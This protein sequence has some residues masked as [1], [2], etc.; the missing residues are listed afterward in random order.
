[1]SKAQKKKMV[2]KIKAKNKVPIVRIER[3]PDDVLLMIFKNF[4]AKC[5]GMGECVNVDY[6]EN[7]YYSNE[8]VKL[9]F[10]WGHKDFRCFYINHHV[11]HCQLLTLRGVC[12]RFRKIVDDRITWSSCG[13]EN[14]MAKIK[15]ADFQQRVIHG[16]S[17]DSGEIICSSRNSSD[18]SIDARNE[19]VCDSCHSMH[20]FKGEYEN[21]YGKKTPK[22]LTVS[23]IRG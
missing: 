8:F 16:I 3:I 7:Y 17:D 1:M 21:M 13:I 10:K 9:F 11:Q 6:Y 15:Q 4:A 2:A 5:E 22:Y 20:N 12:Q 19:I 14:K 18:N 23:Q